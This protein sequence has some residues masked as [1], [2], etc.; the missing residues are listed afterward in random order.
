MVSDLGDCQL[1]T[2]GRR[3]RPAV[4]YQVPAYAA[5]RDA[6]TLP[7]LSPPRNTVAT[8]T[9]QTSSVATQTD[10]GLARDPDFLLRLLVDGPQSAD[11]SADVA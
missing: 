10:F 7:R 5:C 8:M 9:P 2:T 11:S 4:Y 3:A 6:A 1:S